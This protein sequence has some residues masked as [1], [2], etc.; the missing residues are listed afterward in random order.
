MNF[1]PMRDL[2]TENR[3]LWVA[4]PHGEEVI[5]NKNVNHLNIPEGKFDEVV[6]ALR[7]A[8]ATTA[9]SS[10]R[11]RASKEGFKS[12]DEIEHLINEARNAE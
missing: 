8:K 2:R 10:M 4:L 5:T 1:H 3:N 6:Q 7:Q 12:D 9:I 11:E